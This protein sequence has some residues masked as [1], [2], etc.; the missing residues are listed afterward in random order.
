MITFFALFGIALSR[1]IYPTIISSI[2][3]VLI[4]CFAIAGCDAPYGDYATL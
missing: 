1:P 4:T 3:E 2:Q